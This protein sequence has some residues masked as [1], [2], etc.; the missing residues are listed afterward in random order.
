MVVNVI[1]FSKDRPLQLHATLTSFCRHCVDSTSA[2]V[3][4]LYRASSED[5]VRA[6]QDL[7]RQ[8][9]QFARL[10]WLEEQQF[11]RDLL[12]LFGLSLSPTHWLRAALDFVSRRPATSVDDFVLFLVDDTIFVRPFS[13]AQ[14]KHALCA[15]PKALAFS[16]RL[17]RNTKRCYTQRCSQ[18]S[19]S[20]H[21][22]E[23]DYLLFRWVGG[24]GDFGYP[25]E[26]S[27][28]VYRA[29]DIR[30]LLYGLPY[31]NPNRLEQGLSLCSRLFRRGKPD[32]LCYE[33]SVA[34]CAPINKVQSVLDNRAG[35]DEHYSSESL[36]QRFLQGERIDVERL[37]GFLPE[38]AHQ[39]I[40]LPLCRSV[41]EP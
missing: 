33:E 16:L 28:S 21:S 31:G 26:L 37:S 36:N 19:P 12:A 22:V 18:Q 41:R 40:E 14:M 29:Q 13:L 17:G 32:L 1:I 4:V 35:V 25:L 9:F 27:S 34:F 6:Y 10:T 24:E 5:F 8:E 3:T 39:E 30:L 38:A 11:K 15:F 20:F 2:S 23:R 7:C